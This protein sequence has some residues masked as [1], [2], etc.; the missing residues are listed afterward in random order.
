MIESESGMVNYLR[1]RQAETINMSTTYKSIS[2]VMLA[3]KFS[4]S[5][6]TSRASFEMSSISVSDEDVLTAEATSAASPGTFI[7]NVDALAL[8][9]QIASQGFE[10][11]DST[12]IGTGTVQISV[13]DG[14][15]TT[16]TIDSTNDTLTGLK[17]AINEANI[18]VT[19]TIVDDGTSKN[20]YRLVL[21]ADKT[22]KKNAINF[23][24]SL[25]GGTAPDFATAVFDD[26]ETDGISADS[27]STIAKGA[28]AAY[29]GNQNKT[30]TFTVAGAGVQTVGAGDITIN[31]TDGTNSGT[32]VVSEADTEV[33]LTG[34]GADGLKL[35]FGAGD[36]KAGD[37]FAVQAFAPT[38]QVAAD[39]RVSLGSTVGGGSPIVISSETNEVEDLIAGVTLHLKDVSTAPV[40]IEV[41]IDKQGIKDKI[42]D[43]LNKYNE[44][45]RHIDQQFRYN[46][47]TGEAGVLLG[48]GYL[49]SMQS[50]L[51][52][53]VSGALS[54]LPT[55]MNM[56]ASIGIRT[57]DGGHLMLTQT[58]KLFDAIDEDFAAVK[59]LFT[60]S[61]S[62]TNPL[63]QFLVATDKTK[64][65]SDGYEVDITQAAAQGY[66]QGAEI[67]DPAAQSIIIDST[68]SAL[69]LTVDGVTSET[70]TLTEK[71]YTSAAEL[72][73]E[74][75]NKINADDNIGKYNMTAEWVSTGGDT[76]YLLLVSPSYGETSKVSIDLGVANSANQA[77]GLA[78]AQSVAGKNVA[79]TINGEAATGAGRV[80]TGDEGNA[81]T[82]GLKLTVNLTAADLT[83][84][85]EA[86]V[87]YSQGFAARLDEVLESITR[88]VDG[89]IARR[90]K[91]LDDQV[92]YYAA[93]IK[94]YAE[95]LE[96]RREQLY[97]QFYEMEQALGELQGQ[98]TYLSSQLA[99]IQSLFG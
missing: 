33:A 3:L 20:P 40:T 68:N 72:V 89:T 28:T 52:S 67:Y 94:D 98:A 75:Q 83:S 79:G 56:L 93:L 17:N 22:G 12:S 57:G 96:E 37:T 41:S 39:A 46:E 61:G 19:A 70:I 78:T 60:S 11:A 51:R 95:R 82:E 29:S 66:L 62:S 85:A 42:T 8:N 4:V 24:A 5:L 15:A 49:L 43:I 7:L 45:M 38:L 71:T 86:V 87:T 63:V 31:W 53:A 21:T 97:K 14:S 36:L 44:V 55:S 84:G 76:G 23:T 54:T 35:S 99:Q 18:G 34:D 59:N 91:G 81:N 65:T 50:Y 2:T 90:T 9:H 48:D 47:E 32:I 10:D 92:D 30:Y 6:L 80:L 27:T 77:L 1:V 69:K 73:R 26:V 13:G 16:L 25:S 88:S 74:L 64:I 58:S